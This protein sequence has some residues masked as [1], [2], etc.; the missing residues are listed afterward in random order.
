MRLQV[1][2]TADFFDLLVALLVDLQKPVLHEQLLLGG[3]CI[4]FCKSSVWVYLKL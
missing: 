2:R 4:P 1:S 3:E